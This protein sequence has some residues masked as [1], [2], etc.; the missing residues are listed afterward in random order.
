MYPFGRYDPAFDC[1]LVIIH[2]LPLETKVWLD[3]D[4]KLEVH[5]VNAAMIS[6]E[7]ILKIYIIANELILFMIPKKIGGVVFFGFE[8][9]Q[10]TIGMP[11]E[12]IQFQSVSMKSQMRLPLFLP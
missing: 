7:G 10:Q 1:L 8:D 11:D 5:C 12:I 6:P 2:I 9:E 3:I 4:V